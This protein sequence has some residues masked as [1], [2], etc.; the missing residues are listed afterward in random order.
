MR[1]PCRKTYSLVVDDLDDGSQT[2][3]VGVLAVDQQ[4]TAD[5]NEA[6]VG[7]LNQCFAHCDGIYFGGVLVGYVH[8]IKSKFIWWMKQVEEGACIIPDVDDYLPFG[9]MFSGAAFTLEAPMTF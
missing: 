1:A 2:A 3:I 6:P 4:N 8:S 7:T 5:L 9:W